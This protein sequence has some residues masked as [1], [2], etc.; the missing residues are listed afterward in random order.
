MS[1]LASRSFLRLSGV[2]C[3]LSAVTTLGLIFLSRWFL[4][5][6]DPMLAVERAADPVYLL[7]L[8]VGLVHPA[9]VL[10]GVLGVCALRWQVRPG[11]SLVALVFVAIWATVEAVQQS[12]LLVA[13]QWTW[14]AAW[15]SAI[16]AATR[17][18]LGAYL[19][20]L[21]GASDAL[22]L[23]ILGA[24]VIGN[25]ARRGDVGARQ[26]D[27]CRGGRFRACRRARC[28]QR[29]DVFRG[30]RGAGADDG[31]AV[32]GAAAAGPLPDRRVAVA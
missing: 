21:D 19:T 20:A 1:V 16:D 8:V 5:V 24:F 29:P 9:F 4:P 22:F 17:D 32:P 27:P 7:R 25:L 26:A 23:V 18:R 28:H 3:G 12:L 2:A 15:V 6:S 11:A 30:W 31:G 10:V 14:R 13:G